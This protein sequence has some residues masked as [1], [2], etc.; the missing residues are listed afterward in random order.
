MIRNRPVIAALVWSTALALPQLAWCAPPAVD[1]PAASHAAGDAISLSEY[2]NRLQALDQLVAKCQSAMVAANC[3]RDAVGPDFRVGLPAGMRGV[4]F[5]WLRELMDQAAR[6]ETVRTDKATADKRKADAGKATAVKDAP[7]RADVKK[8]SDGDD[9]AD[10]DEKASQ[11]GKQNPVL[12]VMHEP[13]F[14]PSTLAQRLAYAR[15]RLAADRR[16]A[17]QLAGP[18]SAHDAGKSQASDLGLERKALDQI[19]VGKEYHTAVVG[20]SIRDRV[21][22]R[23]ARWINQ[24][25]GKVVQAGFKSEWVGRTAEIVFVVA[26][27]IALVWFLIRLER[28]G[29]LGPALI[30][31]GPAAGAA[32]IR[33]WQLWLQDARQAAAA[34]AWRDAIHLLY[35]ASISRL[36]S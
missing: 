11:A 18:G 34:G 22:E 9:D 27:C 15:E 31:S 1:D 21:L 7:A 36:E 30:R 23:A 25:I 28:Q 32:S 17:E 35:W 16:V 14:A 26:L 2:A 12:S 13:E 24:V 4:R 5:G 6:G 33:D 10:S 20:P 8:P 3:Q 29:R 19:L